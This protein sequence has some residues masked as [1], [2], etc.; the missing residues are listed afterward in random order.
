MK[1]KSKMRWR[2]KGTLTLSISCPSPGEMYSRIY[3]GKFPSS[4]QY[5][6]TLRVNF[7]QFPFF[8]S[9]SGNPRLASHESSWSEMKLHSHCTNIP[10]LV[11]QPLLYLLKNNQKNIPTTNRTTWF[12]KSYSQLDTFEYKSETFSQTCNWGRKKLYLWIILE[13]WTMQNN[14][15]F[16]HCK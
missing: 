7:L 9:T 14:K 2:K 6:P 13:T 4:S 16:A 10:Q 1:N 12:R 15:T 8:Q 5:H 3:G 11:L